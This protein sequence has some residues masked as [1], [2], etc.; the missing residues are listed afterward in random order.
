MNDEAANDSDSSD[1]SG[2]LGQELMDG[3]IKE[4]SKNKYGKAYNQLIIYLSDKFPELIDENGNLKLELLCSE[5][6]KDFFGHISIKRDKNGRVAH[7]P[8]RFQSFSHVSGFNSGIKNAFTEKGI[9]MDQDAADTIKKILSGYKRKVANLKQ[10]GVM[11]VTEGKA[12]I[13]FDGYK[14]IAQKAILTEKQI[15]DSVDG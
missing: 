6:L 14:T 8:P 7:N 3:R 1:G 9:V 15:I 4:K 13:T 10:Q 11:K 12:Q 5:H 2:R